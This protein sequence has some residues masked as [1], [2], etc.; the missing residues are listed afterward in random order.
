MK[1]RSCIGM[2]ILVTLALALFSCALRCCELKGC[3]NFSAD[4][5]L[6]FIGT[7]AGLDLTFL[8]FLVGLYKYFTEKEEKDTPVISIATSNEPENFYRCYRDTDNDENYLHQ[9]IFIEVLNK[10]NKQIEKPYFK[11]SDGKRLDIYEG[12]GPF[13]LKTITPESL[14]DEKYIIAIDI[15]H[16]EGMSWHVSETFE[17]HYRNH[18]NKKFQKDFCV[19]L[20][21]LNNNDNR[22]TV[23]N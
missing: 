6:G 11:T 2:F 1:K 9:Q 20:A 23:E 7:M 13:K 15:P 22:I 8:G 16:H 10:G 5:W 12:E 4:A 3:F 19:Y 14:T 18:N 21:R 17:F